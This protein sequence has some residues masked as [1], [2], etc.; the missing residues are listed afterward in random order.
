MQSKF[1]LV[2]VIAGLAVVSANRVKRGETA[3]AAGGVPHK[4]EIDIFIEQLDKAGRLSQLTT[5]K[6]EIDTIFGEKTWKKEDFKFDGDQL[7]STVLAFACFDQCLFREYGLAGEGKKGLPD[8]ALY[9]QKM[10]QAA[11]PDEKKGFENALGALKSCRADLTAD[12]LPLIKVNTDGGLG[13][14]PGSEKFDIL[15]CIEAMKVDFC[16]HKNLQQGATDKAVVA[17]SVQILERVKQ[18]AEKKV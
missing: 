4:D 10:E 7:N 15:T 14:G 17:L 18:N 6:N 8:P 12:K 5:C 2:F 3:G 11:T 1:F 9:S 13:S 16:L